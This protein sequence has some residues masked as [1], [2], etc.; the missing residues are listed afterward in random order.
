ML[1]VNNLNMSNRIQLGLCCINTELRKKNVFCSRTLIRK[2]FTVEKAKAL[3][4]QN[5]ADIETLCEWNFR[6]NIYVLR[7]SSDILPH[8]TDP[9]VE[10]YDLSFAKEALQRAGEAV[11]KY[12]Q[13]INMHPGQFNQVGAHNESIFQKTCA[14]LKMHAD[15]LDMMNIDHNGILCV[16]G[17]GVYND[18][19]R[20]IQRWI[21]NYDR[22]PE[23][24][25]RRLCIE[26]CEKCYS[27]MDCLRIAETCNIPLI[28]DTHHFE[29]YNLLKKDE[30]EKIVYT[31]DFMSRVVKTWTSRSI[32]PL[33]HISEQRPNARIG[34]HSDLIET[35]PHY[36]LSLPARY[37]VS[38]DIEVEAKSKEIAILHLY[39]RYPFLIHEP[40]GVDPFRAVKPVKPVLVIE[41]VIA[42]EPVV[43]VEPVIDAEPV[44]AVEPVVVDPIVAI[45]A[46]VVDKH[47]PKG[48]KI[49][50]K[51]TKSP[52]FS[53]AANRIYHKGQP[54]NK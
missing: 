19:E 14:D 7:L 5:I 39:E 8:Y 11:K 48:I 23:N 40:L 50:R 26:N 29:C 10:S 44:V 49:S 6:H 35:I 25:K 37:N 21:A 36:I 9:E 34:A 22:L 28:F 1:C 53:T 47:V 43:A 30:K 51:Y 54:V 52:V 12:K 45:V 3:A 32:T 20:T 31:E 17:G 15:L 38:L 24:V 42:A 41:P 46:A 4:L 18:K 16:H 33:F 2:N 13:R 27:V